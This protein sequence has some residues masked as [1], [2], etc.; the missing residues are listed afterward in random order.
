LVNA[1]QLPSEHRREI[2]LT[3]AKSNICFE[4]FWKATDANTLGLS[5]KGCDLSL[6]QFR[7][8]IRYLVGSG[9]LSEMKGVMVEKGG[10]DLFDDNELCRMRDAVG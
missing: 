8:H 7:R 9:M 4:W 6:R 2:D 10:N 3:I 5:P 1:K